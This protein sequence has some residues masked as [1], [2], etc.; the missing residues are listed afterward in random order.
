VN[1]AIAREKELIGW[2]RKNK[3]ELVSSFNP[4]WE[5]LNLEVCGA[6]PPENRNRRTD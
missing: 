4:K 1:H 5:F 6:W 3:D 2:I